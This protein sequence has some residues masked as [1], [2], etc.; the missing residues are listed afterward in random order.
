M[1]LEAAQSCLW[2]NQVKN[3]PGLLL[4]LVQGHCFAK[5]TARSVGHSPIALPHLHSPSPAL[6]ARAR[7]YSPPLSVYLLVFMG[8]LLCVVVREGSPS[9]PAQVARSLP[10]VRLCCH[11]HSIVSTLGS[12][13]SFVG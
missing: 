10:L 13:Y 11:P 5:P 1:V 8:H 3:T 7:H 4:D 2:G 12:F 9:G 6:V